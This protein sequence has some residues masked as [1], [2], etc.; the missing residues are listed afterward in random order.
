VL[1]F[2]T[3]KGLDYENNSNQS[4]TFVVHLNNTIYDV[5]DDNPIRFLEQMNELLTK[6]D[7]ISRG[8]NNRPKL[9]PKTEADEEFDWLFYW[10]TSYTDIDG[11]KE[12]SSYRSTYPQG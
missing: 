3:Q 12:K 10:W 8:D 1:N 11:R 5:S 4:L 7:S 6:D 2:F 9:K